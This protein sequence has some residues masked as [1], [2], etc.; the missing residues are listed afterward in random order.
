MRLHHLLGLVVLAS[1]SCG[2]ETPTPDASSAEATPRE[3]RFTATDFAFEGPDVIE[4]GM[5]TMVL[6]NR[7][8][9]WHHVQLVKLPDGMSL[10]DFQA[11]MAGMQPGSPPPPWLNEAGGVNPPT[12]GDP[13]RV[14]MLVEPGEYAVL[15]FVDTPDKVPHVMK[16]MIRPLTVTPASAAPAPLPE[17]DLSLTLVDYAFAFSAP[18][19]AGTHAVRVEVEAEQAHEVAFFRFEPGKTMDDL[20]AWAQTYEGTPPVTPV[21]GVPGM[22][23][24]QT[25]I[26][27]VTFE[28]GDYVAL[29]FL[30]DATDG[31]LHL[32]HGMVLPFHI[33]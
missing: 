32:V 26:V 31:Q 23:Q 20:M 27:H 22:R 25:A 24:G 7:G 28:P 10:E 19:T 16:G 15:C 9:T 8:E 11:G 18:P 1:L 17:S 12:P 14:T 21:G 33:S 6:D 4:S 29:C 2:G 3:V 5:I 13:A 30:P